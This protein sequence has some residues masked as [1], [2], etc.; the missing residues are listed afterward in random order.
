VNPALLLLADPSACLR[1]RALLELL[2][3]PADD[4]EA[5]E[6][7]ALREQDELAAVIFA[8]QTNGGAWKPGP[9]LTGRFASGSTLATAFAL[10]R[11]GSLGFDRAHPAVQ[12]GAEALFSRQLPD[13]SWPLEERD[14]LLDGSGEI[15]AS[16]RYTMIPLQTAFPLRGLAACGYAQD[17]R[18]ERAYGWLLGQRLE[19]GAWPTGRAAGVYGGVAGY[20]RLPRSRW[21]C[22]TNTT[23]ALACL[24]LHPTLRLSPECGR[25]LDLLLDRETREASHLGVEVARLAGAEPPRG[26]FTYFARFDLAFLLHLC[27]QAG[28]SPRERRVADL[29]AYLRSLQGEVGLWEHPLYPQCSRWLTFDLLNSLKKLDEA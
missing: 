15:P 25:A 12:N 13:G 20:R 6:L 18:A 23:A 24:A 10:A 27:A 21:G 2:D 8:G 5:L 7:Q 11:L 29:I 1:R 26:Y 4:P 17:P 3:L 14:S 22:R 16:E 9:G 28:A 19:D